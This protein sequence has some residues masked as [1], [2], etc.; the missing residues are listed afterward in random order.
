MKVILALSLP[1]ES[2]FRNTSYALNL[3]STLLLIHI[4]TTALYKHTKSLWIYGQ[5]ACAKCFYQRVFLALF[6]RGSY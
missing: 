5:Y 6:I 3:I 1:D 2:Y 4:C